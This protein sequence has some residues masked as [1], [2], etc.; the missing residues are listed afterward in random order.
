[1]RLFFLESQFNGMQ[2]VMVRVLNTVT[3]ILYD[4]H[5]DCQS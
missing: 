2:A 5:N 1:M 4:F 3:V